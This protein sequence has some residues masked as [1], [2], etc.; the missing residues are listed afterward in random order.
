ML[1]RRHLG[2]ALSE[3]LVCT[4]IFSILTGL[5][6]YAA[7]SGFRMFTHGTSRQALQR[8]TRAIIAWLQRDLGLSN[9]FRCKTSEHVAGG[10]RKD[11]LAL[12]GM[13]SWQEPI[14]TDALELPAWDRLIVYLVTPKGALE[15][16]SFEASAL[17]LPV[18]LDYASVASGLSQAEA[19][20]S[21]PRD[22]RQLSDSVRTFS[23]TLDQSRNTAVLDLVLE[24]ATVDGG[25]GKA[26][27]EVLQIQTTLT[28]RN[29]WPRL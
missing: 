28:P 9:L 18:P 6:F 3:L 10:Y 26:R 7:A 19:K 25:S 16:I 11:S 5:C 24:T 1:T 4:V 17:G 29:T 2:F 21:P 20:S 12:V 22:R 14:A 23:V 15:R 13:S 27:K 8:D